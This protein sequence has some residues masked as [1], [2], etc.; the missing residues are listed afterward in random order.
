MFSSLKVLGAVVASASALAIFTPV[1]AMAN[2]AP[3]N[4]IPATAP[5]ACGGTDK[6]VQEC[7]LVTGNGLQVTSIGGQVK[8]TN[9]STV[10]VEVNVT[11][12][13]GH[14]TNTAFFA[15]NGGGVTP[16]KTWHNPNPNA[17]VTPGDYCTQALDQSGNVLSQACVSVHS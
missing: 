17:N 15:V 12:P 1:A 9:A 11:G 4:A 8:N 14:I 2:A 3:N 7:T 10:T 16:F 5:P 13:N 6:G